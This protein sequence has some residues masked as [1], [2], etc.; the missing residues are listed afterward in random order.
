MLTTVPYTPEDFYRIS[1]AEFDAMMDRIAGDISDFLAKQKL[2]VK[3]MVP[4]LR[5]GQVPAVVLSHKLSVINFMPVQV[6]CLGKGRSMVL[7]DPSNVVLPP[8]AENECVIVVDDNQGSGGTVGKAIDIVRKK[9][10]ENVK[11][12]HVIMSVD[13]S[14]QENVKG[15]IFKA[16]GMLTNE[17]A[18]LTDDECDAKG[19]FI[20][21]L[22]CFPWETPEEELKQMKTNMNRPDK[23]KVMINHK[24]CDM[25]PVCGGISVCPTGALYWDEESGRITHDESKCIGCGA[26][27]KECPVAQAIRLARTEVEAEQI[28]AEYDADPRRAEDLFIDRY[29]GDIVLTKTTESENAIALAAQTSGL[30]IMELNNDDLIRCLLMSI[31]MKELFAGHQWKHIKVM[32]PS[33]E[34]LKELGISEITA[35]VFFQDGKQIGKVEGYFENVESERGVLENKIK[36]ILGG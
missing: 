10:G 31:P 26:C 21:K 14:C 32:N 19:I 25:A 15:P 22:A 17:Q 8:V 6:K 34:L 30:A 24:I 11:I 13:Y 9:F 2:T 3:Y 4:V 12:I 5:G 1:W 7:F 20:K 27:T 16:V 33:E 23:F 36:K 28:Q 35:L 29:G 18:T